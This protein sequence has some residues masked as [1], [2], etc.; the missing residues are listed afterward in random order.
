MTGSISSNS[1]FKHNVEIAGSNGTAGNSSGVKGF[2]FRKVTLENGPSSCHSSVSDKVKSC[3][4]KALSGIK[5]F[6]NSKPVKI[7]AFTLVVAAVSLAS[8]G[9][10]PLVAAIA[11]ASLVIG[12]LLCSAT[13]YLNRESLCRE[14]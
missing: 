10:I 5:A 13:S 9:V 8:H 2:G 7:F 3:A 14:F 6:F 12:S 4:Q 11:L 1:P